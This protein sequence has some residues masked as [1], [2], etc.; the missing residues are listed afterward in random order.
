MK[1]V[2]KSGDIVKYHGEHETCHG[3]IYK[4]TKVYDNMWFDLELFGRFDPIDC[5]YKTIL[6]SQKHEIELYDP[7]GIK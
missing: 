7:I 3:F 6:S 2:I 1:E 5:I 4:V